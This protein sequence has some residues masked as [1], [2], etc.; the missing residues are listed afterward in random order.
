M[1]WYAH[2]ISIES[3]LLRSNSFRPTT[4]KYVYCEGIVNALEA[5]PNETVNVNY[6]YWRLIRSL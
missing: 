1:Y 3:N 2:N 4:T 6:I 5:K